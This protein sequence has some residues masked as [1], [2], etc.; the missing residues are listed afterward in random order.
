[1]RSETTTVRPAYSDATPFGGSQPV[2]MVADLV[3]ADALDLDSD[4][5]LWVPQAPDVTFKPMMFYSSQ[6]YFV[7]LLR[8]KRSGI[9]SASSPHRAGT[10]LRSA[11]PLALPRARLVRRGG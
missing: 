4:D 5:R 11:R 2:G 6:G 3:L 1:M 9:L 10:R 8:V 7:N